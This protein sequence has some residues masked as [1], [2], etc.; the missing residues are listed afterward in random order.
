VAAVVLARRSTIAAASPS[1]WPISSICSHTSMAEYSSDVAVRSRTAS[2][3][4][5]SGSGVGVGAI[6]TRPGSPLSSEPQAATSAASDTPSPLVRNRPRRDTG[7]RPSE[8][9]SG[10]N[11]IE[12]SFPWG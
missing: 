12:V 7:A 4:T 1:S 6:P 3:T 10:S 8:R 11:V 5:A 9:G 2:S